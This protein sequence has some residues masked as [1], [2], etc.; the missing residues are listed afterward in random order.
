VGLLGLEP[1]G[2]LGG[3]DEQTND[4]R[5][6]VA[7]EAVRLGSGRKPLEGESRT[8]LRGETNPQGSKRSKPSRA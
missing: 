5:A 2:Q 8:W 1:T 6:R 4:K 3:R 7:D